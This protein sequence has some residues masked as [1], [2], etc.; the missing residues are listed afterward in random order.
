MGNQLSTKRKIPTKKKASSSISSGTY[1]DSFHTDD[2]SSSSGQPK[3]LIDLYTSRADEV[4]HKNEHYLIKHLFQR[5]YFAPIE[6]ALTQP[7]SAVLDVGCGYHASWLLDM[8]VEFPQCAFHGF[9]L[10]EPLANVKPANLIP[11]NCFL[12]KHDLFDG[13]PYDD[14][15]FDYIHQSQMQMVYPADKVSWMLEEFVRMTKENGMVELVESDIIPKRMGPLFERLFDGVR[16]FIRE[17]FGTPFHGPCLVKRMSEAGLVDIQTD[18]GS[19]PLCWGGYIGK[20]VYED[21][22]R[23]FKLAGSTLAPY[24]GY[25]GEYDPVEFENFLDKAFDECVEYQTYFNVR[26]ACGRKPASNL[27]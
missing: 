8:A 3:F 5:N 13:F 1:S 10:V 9:D 11:S 16:L 26:W 4:Y 27:S 14:N 15:Q 2:Q 24:M 17:Y 22:L 19:L 12:K 18:Y 25:E 21:T 23:M 7:G 6:N 20:L